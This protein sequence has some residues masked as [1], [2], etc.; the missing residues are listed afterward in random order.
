MIVIFLKIPIQTSENDPIEKKSKLKAFRS[1]KKKDK[2]LDLSLNTDLLEVNFIH[3]TQQFIKN[4]D[5]NLTLY[6]N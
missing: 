2:K 5:F 4:K 6:L 3:T 1:N